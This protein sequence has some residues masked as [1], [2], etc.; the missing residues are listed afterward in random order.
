MKVTIRMIFFH[1]RKIDL[2]SYMPISF[3]FFFFK[4]RSE[5]SFV[6]NYNKFYPLISHDLIL[7]NVH[8]TVGD[9]AHKVVTEFESA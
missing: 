4:S 2:S 6:P 1:Y 9:N 3:F 8:V 7:S 5:F